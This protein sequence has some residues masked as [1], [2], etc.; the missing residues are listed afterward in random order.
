V[1]AHS[2]DNTCPA[3]GASIPGDATRGL[4]PRCLIRGAL[5]GSN[6]PLDLSPNDPDISRPLKSRPEDSLPAKNTT[7]NLTQKENGPRTPAQLQPLFPDLEIIDLLGA[8]GMGA[9][10]KARQPRLNR[11]VALK[12]LTCPPELHDDFALRFE[13][14]AQTLARLNHPNIVTIHDFG[15]VELP[16]EGA[17]ASP[18]SGPDSLSPISNLQSPIVHRQSSIS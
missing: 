14:E 8:G 5:Y 10:Y 11:F 4:C 15:E 3:C 1:S 13:H 12:V 7:T 9:V 17:S 6:S 18:G 16:A 2:T